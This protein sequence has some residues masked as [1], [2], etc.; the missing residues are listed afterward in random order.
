MDAVSEIKR[1]IDIVE[2]IGRTTALKRSGRN[3]SGLCPFHA[4]K[5][6]SF[7]VTPDRGM[8][9]CYGACGE[10]GDLFTFVQKR[11]N[12]DFRTALQLLAREAGV[13]L[14]PGAARRRSR[15]E[16]LAS[17]V[18]AAVDF[19]EQHLAS[20]AGEA[21]RAYLEGRGL[22]PGTVSAFR[23][24]WAPDDWRPLRDHLASRGYSDA[25][26]VAAGVLIAPESGGQ[27]Y[28]RF[29][30]RI[31]IPIADE[32]GVFVALAG[33]AL[34]DESPKYLN[35]P[36]T[37]IFDKGRTLFGLDLAST[38]AREQDTVVVVEGY[39]DVIGPWQAGFK[40]V[41]ATMGTSL[42]FEH[43]A[44]LRRY[45]RR[46]VLAMD[47]DA[48]GLAA[49]ERA[50]QLLMDSGSVGGA[51]R[52]VRS[53]EA[54]AGR[55]EIDL[56]VAPLPPGK[57]P[58]ETVRDDP[59]AWATA[60][61]AATPYVAFL[62]DRLLGDGR[63]ASPVEARRLV[64][65]VVPVLEEVRDPVERGHYVQKIARHLGIHESAVVERLRNRRAPPARGRQAAEPPK[66]RRTP[67][68]ELLLATLLR[69]PLLRDDV[70]HLP[71]DLFTEAV[72]REAFLRWRHGDPATGDGSED[73]PV[74]AHM[75]D[76]LA[77]RQPELTLPD[78][79]RRVS[80]FIRSILRER[81]IQRQAALTEQ[82]AEAERTH[83]ARK[84]EEIAHAA[85]Q[86]VPLE[87]ETAALAQT[88]IEELELGLSLHRHEGPTL[89]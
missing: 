46:V 61:A 51:A 36:Q 22:L 63:P 27:P 4:E 52:S 57:D 67:V 56:R 54:V 48:A 87:D 40:N 89:A 26:A 83:G 39:M 7:Y 72:N 62:I 1:R 20:T 43:A 12:V 78:A 65:Q 66:L 80:D 37:E 11:D 70:R 85:W 35:S 88:V 41:V 86:G 58:D 3:Y 49:A 60:I 16:H 42:T 13:E 73:D 9:R 17:I 38:A 55:A 59:D 69:Y 34:G 50:G 25:D 77:R 15:A 28:D 19:Y 23:L 31:I 6:P 71:A 32:R 84:V 5:T 45:A 29:R 24:G 44:I 74:G 53:A 18:S 76:L 75:R 81:L 33:R 14:S 47:P 79:R 8:W 64:D 21:A 30:G 10:G 68:E 82:L 2:Y